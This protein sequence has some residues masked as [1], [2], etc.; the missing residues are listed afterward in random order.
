MSRNLFFLIAALTLTAAAVFAQLPD[1]D[2][3]VASWFYRAPGEFVGKTALGNFGRTVFATGPFLALAAYVIAFAAPRLGRVW[4]FA[5][6]GREVAF[7]A[8]TLALGPGLLVNLSL[9]DHTHRPRPAH[10]QPYGGPM[11][12]RPFYAVDGACPKNCSFP[13][14]EAAASFWLVAPALLAPPPL[15]FAAVSAALLFGAAT[16]LLRMAFGG[17]FLSDVVFAALIM[18]L[19]IGVFWRGFFGWGP[20]A[21]QSASTPSST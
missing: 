9:K 19:L 20:R 13:S 6:S 11:Q 15:R 8:A 16:G 5:P 7:L 2:L 4:R 17:H 1:L 12:F 14:G 10:I 3:A 21:I 18:L